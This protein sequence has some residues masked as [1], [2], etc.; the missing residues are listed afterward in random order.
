[1]KKIFVLATYKPAIFKFY[2]STHT[3]ETDYY[4]LE[5]NFGNQEYLK[6]TSQFTRIK[7]AV[8][9]DCLVSCS[10]KE[11]L[12]A[13]IKFTLVSGSDSLKQQEEYGE[14]SIENLRGLFILYENKLIG[15][16][17]YPKKIKGIFERNMLNVRV[18]M[19]IKDLNLIKDIIM[20]N[21]SKTNINN[22]DDIL[23]KFLRECKQYFNIKGDSDFGKEISNLQDKDK[24][25]TKYGRIFNK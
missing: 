16:F 4:K 20:T 8:Y 14:K 15:P 21:K 24:W 9:N 12:L 23:I 10:K 6:F 17:G 2:R 22:L 3:K 7:E 25:N 5:S 1:M 19:E 11:E 18:I 13:I